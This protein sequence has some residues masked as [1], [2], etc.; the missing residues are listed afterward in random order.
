MIRLP[1][2]IYRSICHNNFLMNFKIEEYELFCLW[3]TERIRISETHK[4]V[5]DKSKYFKY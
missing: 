2:V 4:I 1:S 3:N 5:S